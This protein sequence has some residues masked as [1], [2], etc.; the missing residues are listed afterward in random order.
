[1]NKKLQNY[2]KYTSGGLLVA[3]IFVECGYIQARN[4]FCSVTFINSDDV[5]LFSPVSVRL[6]VCEQ[7]Y[8]KTSKQIFM[9]L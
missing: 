4:I 3:H 7:D 5:I 2:I 9:K 8:I 1:M 6:L